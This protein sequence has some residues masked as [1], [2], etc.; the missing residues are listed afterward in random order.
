MIAVNWQ[1]ILLLQVHYLQLMVLMIAVNW[2]LIWLLQ[3]Q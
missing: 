3:I 2:Q 1:L